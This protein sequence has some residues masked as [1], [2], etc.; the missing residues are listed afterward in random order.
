MWI[1]YKKKINLNA[2]EMPSKVEE[3]PETSLASPPYFFEAEALSVLARLSDLASLSGS[4][5][6]GCLPRVELLVCRA[7]LGF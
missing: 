1:E 3:C 5:S 4:R 2:H 6:L 7:L